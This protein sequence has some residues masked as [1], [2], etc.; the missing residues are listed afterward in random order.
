MINNTKCIYFKKLF[1]DSTQTF[2][3]LVIIKTSVNAE[4]TL[5][6][7]IIE[8]TTLRVFTSK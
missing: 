4:G 5:T 3:I 6:F 1:I 2:S 8:K 7:L